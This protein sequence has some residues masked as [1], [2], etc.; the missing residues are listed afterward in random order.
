[1]FH[2]HIICL[3][4]PVIVK[5]VPRSPAN[6]I[7]E[8]TFEYPP[9]RQSCRSIIVFVSFVAFTVLCRLFV[10][11]RTRINWIEVTLCSFSSLS[12]FSYCGEKHWVC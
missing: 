8:D 2:I 1:M 5:V 9:L 4:A 3:D 12:G 11:G 7:N 6:H 10:T